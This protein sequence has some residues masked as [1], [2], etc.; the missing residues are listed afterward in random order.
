M[1]C[2]DRHELPL[3]VAQC[4]EGPAE[5]ASGVDVDRVVEPL[6]LAH[7]CVSVDDHRTTAVIRC[8]VQT[9]W[10][11]ELVDLTGRVAVE[12][13]LADATRRAAGV[14]RLHA[15]MR[16]DELALIEDEV[17]DES[18]DELGHGL[19][20]LRRL[21]VELLDRLRQAVGELHVL[22]AQLAQ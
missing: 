8:P 4:S 2:C 14:L 1:C 12:R 10:Q 6:G 7:R 19:A 16:H 11:S 5:H 15:S 21:A 9:D 13:E 18:I 22:A 17:A 3:R 20:E